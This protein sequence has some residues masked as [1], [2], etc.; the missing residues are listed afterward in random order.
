MTEK[1][2]KDIDIVL[3]LTKDVM[4][5]ELLVQAV[6]PHDGYVYGNNPCVINELKKL[7]WK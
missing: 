5:I 7:G 3:E 6:S 2:K 1:T 4:C